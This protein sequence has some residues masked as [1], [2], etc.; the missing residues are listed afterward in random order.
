M[1]ALTSTLPRRNPF[2]ILSSW[3]RSFSQRNRGKSSWVTEISKFRILS[4]VLHK[5]TSVLLDTERMGSR[6]IRGAHYIGPVTGRGTQQT[7]ADIVTEPPQL[8]VL[9]YA[10]TPGS[11][12]SCDHMNLGTSELV[13]APFELCGEVYWGPAL[14]QIRD[15]RFDSEQVDVLLPVST[16]AAAT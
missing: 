4:R 7:T 5:L 3:T 12:L 10:K 9:R 13:A 2:F 1:R 16:V 15:L 6:V 11:N 8:L 14:N